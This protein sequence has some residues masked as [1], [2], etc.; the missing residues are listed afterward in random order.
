MLFH[1]SSTDTGPSLPAATQLQQQHQH[2]HQQ[3]VQH[4]LQALDQSNE[5]ASDIDD[6]GNSADACSDIDQEWQVGLALLKPLA[7]D[8]N[9]S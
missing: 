3:R 5:P 4:R 6:R 1:A 9:I 8:H 2:Q 7:P